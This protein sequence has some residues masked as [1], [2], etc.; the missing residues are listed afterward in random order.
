M[1]TSHCTVYNVQI[2]FDEYISIC[3]KDFIFTFCL[4][5]FKTGSFTDLMVYKVAYVEIKGLILFYPGS[6]LIK[7]GS[8]GSGLANPVLR[9]SIYVLEV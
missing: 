8:S 6:E 7:S 1:I 3:V 4:F 5:S 9:F 2:M